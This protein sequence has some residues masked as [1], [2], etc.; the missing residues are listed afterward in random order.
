[1]ESKEAAKRTVN[2]LLSQAAGLEDAVK[3]NRG[4]VRA[5]ELIREANKILDKNGMIKGGYTETG[6][7][8]TE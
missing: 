6:K 1:M 4:S 7:A 2:G 5:G 3:S 8:L